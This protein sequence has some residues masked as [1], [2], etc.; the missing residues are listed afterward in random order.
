LL[1][2]LSTTYGQ[3]YEA[4]PTTGNGLPPWAY[5]LDN[6]Q[7]GR[8]D[9]EILYGM[10]RTLKPRRMIE[11]GGGHSSKLASAAIVRTRSED[12]AYDCDYMTI[13]PYPS[14]Y[15]RQGFPGFGKLIDRRVQEVPLSV[16]AAL[17]EGDI[18]FIDTSHILATGSDVWWEF[19]EVLPRVGPGV[20]VHVHDIFS[21]AEYPKHQVKDWLHFF[22]E[23]YLLQAFLTFNDCHE[24]LWGSSFMHLF[25][26]R[27]LEAAFGPYKGRHAGLW[28]SSFWIKR[29]R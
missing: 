9:A 27:E 19:C 2:R 8:I 29:V 12:P 18:L 24:V 10:V 15:L 6:P 21:P 1:D 4:W 17:G 26:D 5:Y 7:F 22:N 13:E 20:T 14:D 11:I 3:E 16:F 28:P 23:Q 25:H